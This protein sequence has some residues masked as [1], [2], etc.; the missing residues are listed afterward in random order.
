MKHKRVGLLGV[1][2]NPPHDG[3]IKLA[4][5]ALQFL[6]SDQVSFIP[7]AIPPHKR[8]L[9]GRE[10]NFS[11]VQL[12]TEVIATIDLPFTVK[13]IEIERG[14]VS[15][16]IET[17][18]VRDSY[19]CRLFL[20]DSDHLHDFCNWHKADRILEL[21]SLAVTNRVGHTCFLLSDKL[22]TRLWSQWSG[23]PG[24]L[25]MLPSVGSD[26]ASSSLRQGLSLGNISKEISPR[27]I[28]ALHNG[29]YF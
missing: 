18:S 4:E 23:N 10:D 29:Y 13:L 1:T 20:I 14:G 24:K 22:L 26:L 11:Q 7:T 27:A 19:Y 16:T 15:S 17:L 6:T 25:I 8:K 12:I 2:F 21:A 5:I 3:Y 28:D 9:N